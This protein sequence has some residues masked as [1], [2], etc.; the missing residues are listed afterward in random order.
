G[1]MNHA[2]APLGL[3]W[4]HWDII[5]PVGISFYTFETISYVVDIY[6]GTAKPA[7]SLLDYALFISFFPRLV[8][9]PIMRASQFLPQLERGVTISME[10][11]SVGGQLFLQGALKK[12]LIADNLSMMVDQVYAAPQLFSSGSVWLASFSY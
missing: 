9:G 2:L 1:S 3:E 4:R 11:V 7:K 5:L 6:R 8:A 10:N 12:L